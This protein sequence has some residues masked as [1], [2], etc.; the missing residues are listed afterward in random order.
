VSRA[1]VP[2]RDA[3]LFPESELELEREFEVAALAA[4]A[5]AELEYMLSPTRLFTC[6][7][8]DRAAIVRIV[9]P[10]TDAQVRSVVRAA[11]TQATREARATARALRTRPRAPET[12]RI[13]GSVFN[14]PPTFVPAWRTANSTW[15]DLGDLVA[16]RLE[17]AASDLDA[18]YT[19]YFCLGTEPDVRAYTTPTAA[20]AANRHRLWLG[21]EWWRWWR[22][23]QQGSAAQRRKFRGW[24]ASTLLHEALHIH[25]VLSHYTAT[26]GRPSVNNMYCYD[27]LVARFHGRPPKEDDEMRC[28]TGWRPRTP[29]GP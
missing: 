4:E 5:E 27:T 29:L 7:A 20:V 22:Q 28:R 9:G 14:V 16:L 10:I 1:T 24:M 19:R 6:S 2:T 17:R 18:G 8:A 21:D 12:T 13:F 3:V 23:S 15:R 25:F 11:I 26:P